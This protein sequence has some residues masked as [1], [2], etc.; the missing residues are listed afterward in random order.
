LAEDKEG[1]QV[2]I[3]LQVELGLRL[4]FALII[5]AMI[6]S[7]RH[8]HN[9]PAGARTHSLV[10]LASA[11]FMIVSIYGF[12]GFDHIE[13]VK[14]DPARMAAQVIS[15]MGFLGAG[16]IWKEGY[17]IK[18]LTTATTLWL[19]SG[20]GLASGS[21][22]YIPAIITTVLAYVA[23]YTFSIWEAALFKKREV[24]SR[25][26]KIAEIN[27]PHLKSGLENV[28]RES[29]GYDVSGQPE[30]VVITFQWA[31]S[32]NDPFYLTLGVKEDILQLFFLRLPTNQRSQGLGALIMQI[33]VQWAKENG[34]HK[35]AVTSSTE[36][37]GFWLKNG[38]KQI[39]DKSFVYDINQRDPDPE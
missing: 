36:A 27:I 37:L 14:R 8:F 24:R 30:N 1:I 21:G 26:P 3:S 38:F 19:V 35:I 6:G 4:L 12:T 22:M 15:G 32:Q 34:F 25:L 16:V 7:E 18:G 5:G 28:L 33:L 20:L 11:L 17:T 31:R 2:D 29:L 39:D 23:L 13:A 10:C 9:K